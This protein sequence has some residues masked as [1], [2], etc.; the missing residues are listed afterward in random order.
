MVETTR[1]AALLEAAGPARVVAA[2]DAAQLP[3]IGPGGLLPPLTQG[4]PPALLTTVYRADSRWAKDAWV[5]LQ[6]DASA[7]TPSTSSNLPSLS[8][9]P[10]GLRPQARACY[11]RTPQPNSK[12]VDED[13]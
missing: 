12:G 4:A 3:P 7:E 2:G 1:W 13:E 9:R 8:A 5:A 6:A 10:W 11:K